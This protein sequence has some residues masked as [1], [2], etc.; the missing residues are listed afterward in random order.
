MRSGGRVRCHDGD[1]AAC[2]SYIISQA[3]SPMR[4]WA[5]VLLLRIWRPMA[6]GHGITCFDEHRE[7]P[8]ALGLCPTRALSHAAGCSAHLAPFAPTP[9]TG[10]TLFSLCAGVAIGVDPE[11]V[12]SNSVPPSVAASSRVTCTH[13]SSSSLRCSHNVVRMHTGDAT[14]SRS[15]I[16]RVETYLSVRFA[17]FTISCSVS[18]LVLLSGSGMPVCCVVPWEAPVPWP[19]PVWAWAWVELLLSP[20]L[21][22]RVRTNETGGN[23][24]R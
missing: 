17:L 14:A 13:S 21:N 3:S 5:Y 4:M 8:A 16:Q 1:S 9:A 15:R 6:Y 23:G 19:A 11:G 7:D 18:C 22:T 24:K 12:V 10:T 20:A 2:T